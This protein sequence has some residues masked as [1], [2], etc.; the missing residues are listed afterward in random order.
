MKRTRWTIRQRVI[1]GMLFVFGLLLAGMG[2]PEGVSGAEADGEEY[3]FDEEFWNEHVNAEALLPRTL[4]EEDEEWRSMRSRRYEFTDEYGSYL[5]EYVVPSREREARIVMVRNTGEEVRIP[6]EVDG[7]P[8]TEIGLSRWDYM[9][10]DY[11][12]SDFECVFM[13][14]TCDK[15]TSLILP[16][17]LEQI[18]Y[19]AFSC[20][21]NLKSV[22][23]PSTLKGMEPC[24]EYCYSL[25]ELVFPEGTDMD[26]AILYGMPLKKL[27]ILGSI[28]SLYLSSAM[29]EEF[30]VPDGLKYLTLHDMPLE[31]LFIP[32]HVEKLYLRNLTQ[33]ES[34][35]LEDGGAQL[36]GLIL[37]ELYDLKEIT[38]ANDFLHLRNGV[39]G[40]GGERLWMT[41]YYMNPDPDLLKEYPQYES[42]ME[43][44]VKNERKYA[45]SGIY[46]PAT[47][48]ETVRFT[49]EMTSFTMDGIVQDC[50]ALK[51]V[52]LPE[53]VRTIEV[54]TTYLGRSIRFVV[55]NAECEYELGGQ[56]DEYDIERMTLVTP[57]NSGL[58]DL[59]SLGIGWEPIARTNEDGERELCYQV[60]KG[61]TLWAISRRCGTTVQELAAANEIADPNFILI[62]QKLW[63]PE[64]QE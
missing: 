53:S 27:T 55:P 64:I 58:R 41:A 21:R 8:V 11:D 4:E 47:R 33:L 54:G 12:N 18:G 59:Q 25:E 32:D 48:L 31:S 37:R 39:T 44:S 43:Y 24:F 20:C 40:T 45:P 30:E 52:F 28:E 7:Y 62:G 35:V 6:Q 19:D 46:L 57:V 38:L 34:L 29:L 17:G 56:F 10:C 1:C 15:V 9:Y 50:R 3:V 16:E 49:E 60:E 22:Q 5:Y 42:I 23:L 13:P 61:D 14:S 36:T 26:Y 51:E 2:I 63:L